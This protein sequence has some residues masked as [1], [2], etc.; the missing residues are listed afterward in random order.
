MNVLVPVVYNYSHSN[1]LAIGSFLCAYFTFSLRLGKNITLEPSLGLFRDHRRARGQ[2]SF[3]VWFPSS[4]GRNFGTLS[5]SESKLNG[6]FHWHL[7]SVAS[8]LLSL[9]LIDPAP[10]RNL[11][12]LSSLNWS[13]RLFIFF[14][15]VLAFFF[16][17]DS[18]TTRLGYLVHFPFR[19]PRLF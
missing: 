2:S 9:Q 6:S 17:L 13:F 12:L 14:L 7:F 10:S 15:L 1:M 5:F 18:A 11:F 3:P 19:I 8:Q 4:S 16:S